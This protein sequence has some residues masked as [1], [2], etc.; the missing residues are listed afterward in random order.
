MLGNIHPNI[1]MLDLLDLMKT[2]VY[3]ELQ[4]HINSQWCSLFAIHTQS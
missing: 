3:K 4:I 2:H 1:M